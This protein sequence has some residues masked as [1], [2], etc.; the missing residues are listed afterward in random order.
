MDP[1]LALLNSLSASLSSSELCELKFLCKDKIG[2]RKLE[3]VQS[4]RELFNFLMEQQLIASYN[5][6]LLKSMFKTIKREDLISQLEE[7]IE[8]GEASAPDERP[9]M[10]E[11]RRCNFFLFR[12]F[13]PSDLCKR[14]FE[15]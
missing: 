7:F 13:L 4:G 10:K 5:V 9:D 12:Y 11:R 14:V 6:D 15:T 2:K 1:F 8:E 3:S